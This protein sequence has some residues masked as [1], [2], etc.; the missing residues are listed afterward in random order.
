MNFWEG[1]K[2]VARFVDGNHVWRN[3]ITTILLD[4]KIINFAEIEYDMPEISYFYGIAIYMYMG[5]HNPP[6]FHVKYQD[7]E[8]IV[9]IEAGVVTG[10]FPRRALGLVYEWL[11]L[12]KE[13][14]MENW[15]RMECKQA[16]V[17]IDPLK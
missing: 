10:S 1:F 9:T 6:H 16:V 5:E 12:H 2:A 4:E 8:A 13:E 7:Y 17:K 11:D 3:K 15:K 14:L